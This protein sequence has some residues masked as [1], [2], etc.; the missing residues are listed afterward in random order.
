MIEIGR[1]CIKTAGR[2]AGKLCVILEK[3]DDNFVNIDGETRRKKCN[4]KHL[5]PVD[6]VLEIK[7]GDHEEIKKLF[8][9]ELKISIIDSKPK[10]K[11]ERPMKLR[12]STIK[13]SEDKAVKKKVKKEKK[14]EEK[15]NKVKQVKPEEK[16]AKEEK[17]SQE[18][19]KIKEKTDKEPKASKL[20]S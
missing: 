3:I 10:E 9:S 7:K 14:K 20:N 5:E 16:Q 11:K 13:E 15:A 2:D 4:I 17:T 12:K 19:D 18:E 6:K 8:E 1:L